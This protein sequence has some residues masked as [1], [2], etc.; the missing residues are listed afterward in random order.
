VVELAST[1]QPV[2]TLLPDHLLKRFNKIG[3][4]L[5]DGEAIEFSASAPK[6][7]LE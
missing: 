1:N 2:S 6:S 3:K 5:E 7:Y 4:N